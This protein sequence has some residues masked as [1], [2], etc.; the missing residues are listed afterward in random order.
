MNGGDFANERDI[1]LGLGFVDVCGNNGYVFGPSGSTT[2]MYGANNG[3]C[4]CG[5]VRQ[6]LDARADSEQHPPQHKT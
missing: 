4:K 1:S 6:E 2:A 3:D 5:G